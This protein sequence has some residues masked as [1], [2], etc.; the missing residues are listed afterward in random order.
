LRAD[1][2]DQAAGDPIL[3]V[4]SL[5]KRFGAHTVLDDISFDVW[6]GGIVVFIGPS[7]TGKSTLLRCMNGLEDFQGGSVNFCGSPV[8]PKHRSILEIRR[9]IGMIFQSFNLYPHLTALENVTLCPVKILKRDPEEVRDRAMTLFRRVRLEHRAN[10]YP[11]ELSGGEQQRVAIARALATDPKM[12]M[13]DEPTS[14]LDPE[15]VGEVLLVMKELAE[16]GRTMLIVTHEM[17]FARDVGTKI[18]FMDGGRIVEEGAPEEVLKAPR[19]D[20][21]RNF[22]RRIG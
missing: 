5:V 12:L 21:T 11:A 22:L 16:E 8:L 7:G 15:T 17:S 9:S 18:V 10:A 13:F 4:R 20:R 3:S 6:Q 2:T 14:A 1:A 19:H